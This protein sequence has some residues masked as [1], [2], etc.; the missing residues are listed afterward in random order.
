MAPGV[1][2]TGP[3]GASRFG[4]SVI[5][6]EPVPAQR[7]QHQRKHPRAGVRYRDRRR[8][9]GNDRRQ[10]RRLGG[11][12]PV[13]RRR[14]Q[15]HHQVGRQSV[16]GK[17]PRVAQQRHVADADT[18][19]DR[20]AGD[21]PRASDRQRRPDLRVHG[22]RPDHAR[23]ALVLHVRPDARRSAGPDA[24][25]DHG[26]VRVH[27]RTTTLRG[28]GHVLP[29]PETP[30]PG[31]LQPS[32]PLAGQ[33]QLQPESDDGSAQPGDAQAARAALRA[34]PTAA[35]SRRSCSSRRSSRNGR[36]T[37]SARAPSRPI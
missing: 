10:R 16:L 3:A 21:D 34:R 17:L 19:R 36:S 26:S 6:R 28:Q 18:V 23:S 2:P 14:G 31:E 25:G 35:R 4:G 29:Q 27:G 20:A 22:R 7:R 15:R 24:G 13:Q 1:H 12:R 30:L 32:R 9:P 5:L 37:S 11:V 8:D 33:L